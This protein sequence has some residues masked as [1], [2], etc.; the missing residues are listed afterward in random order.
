MIATGTS[1]TFIKNNLTIIP[2]EGGLF[3]IK[4]GSNEENALHLPGSPFSEETTLPIEG[5]D[6][7]SYF[8]SKT[9]VHVYDKEEWKS[10]TTIHWNECLNR[11]KKMNETAHDFEW[12]TDKEAT[13]TEAGSRHEQC[14]ICGYEKAAV[15]IPA[16]GTPSDTDTPTDNDQTDNTVS[17]KTD[18]NRTCD[19]K[20]PKTGNNDNIALWIAAVL[21][22]GTALNGTILYSR[23]KKYSR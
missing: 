9:H 6:G 5:T 7:N 20:S 2:E 1:A 22:A 3:E 19:I 10:D 16:T 14:R 8:H 13:A 23:K 4:A 18:D 11:G 12:V 15:K 21:A 17:P